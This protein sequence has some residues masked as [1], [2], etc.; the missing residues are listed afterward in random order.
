M[1]ARKTIITG[2]PDKRHVSTSFAER[3]SLSMRMGMRRFTRLTNGFSKRLEQHE[4]A[5]A[6]YFMFCNFCRIHT[7]L[8][9]MPA[10]EVGVCGPRLVAGGSRG[11]D[12]RKLR[13][14]HYRHQA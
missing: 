11:P 10:M 1:G 13:L 6:F 7:T 14:I 5:L 12:R 8:R 4:N 2:S 9:V 3:A